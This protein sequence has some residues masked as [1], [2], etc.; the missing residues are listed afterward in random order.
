MH[1][2][3][4][5]N[6]I[7]FLYLQNIFLIFNI[8]NPNPFMK[9]INVTVKN[10]RLLQDVTMKI[11]DTTTLIVGKNNTGKTS[12]SR[13][14]DI[15]ISGKKPS[16][17]DFSL[18]THEKFNELYND[19]LNITDD[20]K[21][22]VIKKI[23]NEMPKISLLLE[24]KF[25]NSDNLANIKPFMTGLLDTDTTI[26]VLFEYSSSASDKLMEIVKSEI[27]MGGN[28]ANKPNLA[29]SPE[30][31]SLPSL[32]VTNEVER[33]SV[34]EYLANDIE[35]QKP[36]IGVP[37][38]ATNT[39]FT[40][41]IE[42]IKQELSDNY[43][44]IIYAYSE[45]ETREE[46]GLIDVSNLLQFNFINAQRAVDD[47]NVDE[48]SK[49]STLFEQQ[50]KNKHKVNPTNQT[51]KELKN[52]ISKTNENVNEK[53]ATFFKEFIDAFSEFG[54]ANI[55][56]E[57]VEL[58]SQLNA[59]RLFTKD[60]KLYYKNPISSLPEKYNGLGYS[61]LIYILSK[62]L[63]FQDF[64][65][66][67][68]SVHCLLFIEEPEAHMH[69]QMQ[70]VFIKNI[71]RFLS[72]RNFN[73]QIIIS[74]HSS[75]ILSNAKFEC[76]R[77]FN[78][79]A[80][81]T[82][83]K[84]LMTFKPTVNE[85][86]K[87]L[88]QYLTLGTSDLFFADKAILFE[89]T[90]ERILM[91]IFIRKTDG[92]Y[93]LRLSENYISYLEV[94]GAYMKNFKELLEFLELKAL[95]ITDIDC[96]KG[97]ETRKGTEIIKDDTL[98]TSNPT[99][100]TWIPEEENILNLL[101]KTDE[102]KTRNN[103]RVA[104]QTLSPV[105]L[106]L[107]FSVNKFINNTFFVAPYKTENVIKFKCGRSFEEAFIIDNFEFIFDKK[108]SLISIHNNIKKYSDKN[109]ILNN[110]FEIYSYIDRNNKKTDFTFDLLMNQE[111]W[112]VPDYIEE[113]LLWLAEE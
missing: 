34:R 26:K 70:N 110:S 43:R 5:K 86:K 87:F 84:D 90:V 27:N 93:G 59:E 45:S 15:F 4:I 35:N 1:I 13:I 94:G 56:D 73:A 81:K 53:L 46:V 47:S 22:D 102:E 28:L 55:N 104:Y 39:P 101:C 91:P 107:T 82:V 63:V 99:L 111:H 48:G 41:I 12:F 44:T 62:I 32:A 95:I 51:S 68:E 109:D 24:L 66:K 89:G 97:D 36:D 10:F 23:R 11:D 100:K 3:S 103:I 52:T 69:P 50:Y 49:L 14:F 72:N 57:G 67:N 25:N 18:S 80:N 105:H 77:Y 75:H 92:K 58:K 54:F 88:E 112:N 108:K 74:T 42:L 19:Y 65:D 38:S 2:F 79:I 7:H 16:F 60:L 78:K 85:V 17:N 33:E 9:L 29:I 64:F 8:T 71:N 106:F 83:I 21:E 40:N 61:N 31:A 20:N 30:N 6:K 98:L 113:G 76:I 37:N 96:I